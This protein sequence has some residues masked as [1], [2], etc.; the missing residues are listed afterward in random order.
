[1]DWTIMATYL[2]VTGRAGPRVKRLPSQYVEARCGELANG[3][4]FENAV[5]SK[6]GDIRRPTVKTAT[7][8]KREL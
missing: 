7:L 2:V 8:V 6:E 1:M 3:S 5:G 4:T